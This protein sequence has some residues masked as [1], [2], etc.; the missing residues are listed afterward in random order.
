[1]RKKEKKKKVDIE[2]ITLV[3]EYSKFLGDI[4]GEGASWHVLILD[5]EFLVCFVF[6]YHVGRRA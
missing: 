3:E 1:M 5:Y 2:I 4:I 6:M